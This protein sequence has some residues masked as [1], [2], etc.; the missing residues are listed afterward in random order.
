MVLSDYREW[1]RRADDDLI[2]IQRLIPYGFTP[3]N[4]VCYHA[5]QYAE[6]IVKAKIIELGGDFNYVHDIYVLLSDFVRTEEITLARKY[7]RILNRYAVNSRYPTD[8]PFETDE[9]MAEE[10]YNMAIRFPELLENAKLKN[11]PIVRPEPKRRSLLDIFRR[12]K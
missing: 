5:Q 1:L 10:A 11:P 4:V 6:K 3:S 7:A 9:I 2:A 12:R 8:V